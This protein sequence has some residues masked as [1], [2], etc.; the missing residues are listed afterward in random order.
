MQ[1]S[2]RRWVIAGFGVLFV[3]A[4]VYFLS[5]GPEPETGNCVDASGALVGCDERAA[6]YRLAR[7]VKSGRECPSASSKLLTFRSGLY[8]GVALRGAPVPS[9]EYVPCLLLAGAKLAQAP[10]DLAFARGFAAPPPTAAGQASGRIKIRGDDWRIFYVLREG[11]LD[12][13]L[14]AVV[15]NPASVVFAAYITQASA[16]RGQVAAATRCARDAGP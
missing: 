12:P 9:S 1:G 3:V 5:S 7:E 13:G 11:Q 2:Q 10:A 4:L 6:R 8:C 14:A 15:A 16:H